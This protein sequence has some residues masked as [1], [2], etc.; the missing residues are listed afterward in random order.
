MKDSNDKI[1]NKIN[2]KG[3]TEVEGIDY[4]FTRLVN[5]SSIQDR[6]I[7]KAVRD[8]LYHRNVLAHKIGLPDK[9]IQVT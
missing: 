7:K 2:L 5:T 9:V 4:V 6:D 8:F 3:I 1:W